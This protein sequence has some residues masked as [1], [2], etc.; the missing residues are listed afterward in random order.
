MKR[1]LVRILIILVLLVSLGLLCLNNTGILS[2]DK[3]YIYR[4]SAGLPPP[5]EV[6]A[7]VDVNVIPMDSER[8]LP[9]QTVLVHN[10]VIEQV[11]STG[12]VQ[13]P[14]DALVV[15]GRGR[16]LMPGLVDM[17]VHIM[18]ENDMLLWFA[19]GVTSVRNMWG[20]TGKMLR[21]GFPDQLA[22]RKQIEQGTLLGPTIYTAGPT[23]EGS[24]SFHPLAEVFDTPEAARAS[25][26][27]QKAQGYDFIKVYDH[28][29]PEVYQAI[30]TAAREHDIPI[31]GHVPLAVG[32]DNVLAGEQQTIEHLSGYIDPDTVEFIISKDQLNE[33][34][35]K[36]REARVW[37]VVTL[38]EYPRSKETPEGFERLKN[39]PGTDY[40]SPAWT[41]LA[42]FFYKMSA[43]AHTYPGA[44]YPQRIAALNREMVQALH[45]A[46][47]GIL[48]GT[49]AAQA[50][51]IPGYSIHEELVMLVEAGLSP[52]EAI[53]AGTR[54]AALVL[55]HSD[56]F[57]TVTLGKRADLLLLDANPLE[58]VTNASKISGIMVRGRWFPQAELQ[59][60]LDGLKDSF[61]PS[62]LERLWPLVLCLLTAF[63]A[64]RVFRRSIA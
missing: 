54:N 9:A 37:N 28:L 35:V 49:D 23:M 44:D 51:N 50:Y 26:A 41:L 8:I 5:A 53:E 18:F 40:Y 12:Q 55:G 38:T 4:Y 7:F 62:L 29:S 46:G 21:F 30:L 19:N 60:M 39:Q 1:A 63:V 10:G 48:L 36:T 52:Y 31:V 17:H 34:A 33:Y 3:P 16:Y 43:D 59:S 6:T 58:D 61:E 32:L 15:D 27:W 20:H 56:D 42:P 25:V 64:I 11:G 13:V 24:P 2:Q 22:L 47:T 57:G 14:H 45:Q